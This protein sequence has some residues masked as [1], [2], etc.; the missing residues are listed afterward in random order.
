MIKAKAVETYRGNP[1]SS[2]PVYETKTRPR[3]PCIEESET[4]VLVFLLIEN[5]SL[6]QGRVGSGRQNLFSI[7]N[8]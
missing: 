5:W 8:K 4:A 2:M 1:R 3:P 6:K 7:P